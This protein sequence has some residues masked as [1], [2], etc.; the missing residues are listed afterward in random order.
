MLE[1][2]RRSHAEYASSPLAGVLEPVAETYLILEYIPGSTV[3][4]E[5]IVSDLSDSAEYLYRY[6]PPEGLEL[7]L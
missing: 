5:R 7:S 3:T 1:A 6:I 4:E 2:I